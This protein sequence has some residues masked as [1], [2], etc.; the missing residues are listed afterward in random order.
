M[1][2]INDIREELAQLDISKRKLKQFAY[3]VGSILLVISVWYYYKHANRDWSYI[4][5]I[6]AIILIILGIIKVELLKGLYKIWMGIA[7]FL[8]WFVSR[9][10][11]SI[12]FYLALTPISLLGRLFRKKWM[13]IDFTKKSDSYWIKR[14]EDKTVD[15]EK[16]Y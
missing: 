10:L 14:D 16:M 11:I 1:S 9:M 5:G 2:W 4:T 7:F 8:G 12:I 15:Y 3:L 6:I 13:D